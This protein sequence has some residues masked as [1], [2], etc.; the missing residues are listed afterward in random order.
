MA[1][2]PNACTVERSWLA[3]HYRITAPIP[4]PPSVVWGL[5][6]D[7]EAFRRW[8]STVLRLDGTIAEGGR[9]R[10]LS[11]V[12]PRAAFRLRVHAIQPEQRR[13]VWGGGGMLSVQ[14][15]RTFRVEDDGTG[16]SL[17]HMDERIDGPLFPVLSWMIPDF[18]ENFNT[19]AADL[20]SAAQQ[21]GGQR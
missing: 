15:I 3:R 7:A 13:M 9:L 18:E 2:H 14:G 16:G 5:L 17:F 1:S 4:A 19:Y 11:T 20:R 8:N 12:L 21:A 10:L 6:T